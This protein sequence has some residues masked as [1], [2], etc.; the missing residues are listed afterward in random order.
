[1]ALSKQDLDT[2]LVAVQEVAEQ[3]ATTMAKKLATTRYTAAKTR[4]QNFE[5]NTNLLRLRDTPDVA[6][7]GPGQN[8]P[9]NYRSRSRSRNLISAPRN[10][11]RSASHGHFQSRSNGGGKKHQQLPYCRFQT[12]RITADK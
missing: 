7:T 8:Q 10:N 3:A 6:A 12:I 5:D 4:E 9:N 2:C 11:N 1:M